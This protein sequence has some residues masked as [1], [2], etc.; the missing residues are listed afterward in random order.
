ME[1]L[2]FASLRYYSRKYDELNSWSI[3]TYL[4]DSFDFNFQQDM[5]F[6]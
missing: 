6:W 5:D 3:N 1:E 2:C 4:I